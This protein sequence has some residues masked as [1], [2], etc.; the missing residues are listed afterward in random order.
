MN[1]DDA[2]RDLACAV[3]LAVA[4]LRITI[5]Q[6]RMTSIVEAKL[7]RIANALEHE[8]NVTAAKTPSPPQAEGSP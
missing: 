1:A 4:E 3:Y 5:K 6:E 2:Y 7:H 8:A